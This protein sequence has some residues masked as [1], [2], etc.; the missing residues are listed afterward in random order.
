MG[1]KPAQAELNAGFKPIF[2]RIPNVYLIHD[3]LIIAT[4]STEEHLK[5]IRE[6]MEV[7][8]SENLTLNP[9]KFTFGSNEIN[10]TLKPN[11]FTFG[12]KEINF[13]AM[14]F[15]SEGVKP[16]PK[17]TK[18]L[19][20][21]QPPKNKEE[22]KS[23][24]CMMQSNS[25]FILYFLKS[26]APLRILLN[27]KECF[28]WT[29]F[30]QSVFHKLLQEFRKETLLTYFDTNKQTFIFMDAHKTGLSPILDQGENINNANKFQWCQDPL[31]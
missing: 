27:S 16:D 7:I 24:I 21:L 12:S 20:D 25:S 30:H 22:L 6:V 8:K 3:D 29:T 10:L 4:K 2:S 9:N 28:K 13:W 18:V 15:S 26:V 23:F 31:T 17:K 11:K 5:A 19:E 14:L 1:V